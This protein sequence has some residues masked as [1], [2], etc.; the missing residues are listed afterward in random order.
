MDATIVVGTALVLAG[1]VFVL[2][3]DRRARKAAKLQK[4]VGGAMTATARA[5]DAE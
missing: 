1:N 4:E 5:A 3:G 2:N